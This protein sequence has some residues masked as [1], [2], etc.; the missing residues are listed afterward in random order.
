MSS[1]CSSGSAESFP[2]QVR[3]DSSKTRLHFQQNGGP[4]VVQVASNRAIRKRQA[5]SLP[6]ALRA[7][8][9]RSRPRQQ[10]IVATFARALDRPCAHTIRNSPQ[11]AAKTAYSADFFVRRSTPLFRRSTDAA[12]TAPPRK[13]CSSEDRL[14]FRAA[15]TTA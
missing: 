4:I 3:A 7:T 12:R 8:P 15:G 11:P 14:L 13:D 9:A 6:S 10:G 5:T 2:L 1:Q